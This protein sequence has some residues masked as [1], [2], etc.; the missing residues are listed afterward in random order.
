[1][2]CKRC[3]GHLDTFQTTKL[4]D[5]D[6]A[7][8]STEIF[9]SQIPPTGGDIILFG[10]E[11]LLNWKVIKEYIPWFR[12][13]DTPA[14]IQPLLC[15]NGLLL[16]KGIIDFL[17]RY[18]VRPISLSLDG[19]YSIYKTTR[20]ISKKQYD[21]II[22]IMKYA[23]SIDPYFIVPFCVLKKENISAAYDILSYLVSLGAKIINLYRDLSEDWTEED[24]SELVK[25]ANAVISKY[26]IV[27]QPFTESIFDCKTCYSPGIMIY[28][29]G[30]IYDSC[31]TTASVLRD[32]G[33]ISEEECQV[34]YMGNVDSFNGF[35]LDIE[36]KRQIIRQHMDCYLIHE[37][38]YVAIKRLQ[39][40]MNID[41]PSFRVMEMV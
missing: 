40:G 38:I 39:E 12:S 6:T 11:P 23:L 14:N 33:L 22:S 41:Q 24:R 9:L 7:K 31:Y 35:Y 20:E 10:G 28:P 37:D 29:N 27:I 17:V 25:Q 3:Y 34:M 16:S 2:S 36:K 32:R 4:M 1:M 18:N 8:K 15:T 26:G 21:H 5:L 19:D 30:D 13:L